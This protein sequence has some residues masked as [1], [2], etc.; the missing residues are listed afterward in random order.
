MLR[1]RVAFIVVVGSPDLHVTPLSLEPWMDVVVEVL[2]DNYQLHATTVPRCPTRRGAL[3]SVAQLV[4][5]TAREKK[6]APT[7]TATTAD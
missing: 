4:R 2:W 6:V 1:R 3:V 7:T 5:L